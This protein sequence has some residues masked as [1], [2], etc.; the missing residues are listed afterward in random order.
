M[1]DNLADSI[2]RHP[3]R[4]GFIAF[5]LIA[6][7]LLLSWIVVTQDDAETLGVFGLPYFALGYVGIGFLM[8]AWVGAWIAWIVTARR[9][10]RERQTD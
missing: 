9:R 3:R 10:R 1:R 6:F 7:G 2:F 5:N 4:L 8:V